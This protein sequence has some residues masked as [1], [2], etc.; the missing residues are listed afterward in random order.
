M[1]PKSQVLVLAT[2]HSM[3]KENPR[4]TYEDLFSLIDRFRA[5]AIGVEIRPEDLNQPVDYLR[6]SYPYEMIE[7]FQRYGKDKIVIGFDWLGHDLA[8]QLI[9]EGYW[10]RSKIKQL[11][12][13]F[14]EEP[15]LATARELL[16][17]CDEVR[18]E[19]IASHPTAGELNDGRYDLASRIYYQLLRN[20]LRDTRFAELSSFY[21]ERDT[22][23]AENVAS[24][25]KASPGKRL[26]FLLG[27]DHR[28]RAVRQLRK[29][30][31]EMIELVDVASV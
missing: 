10:Q 16:S 11:Q 14:A 9:P 27:G 19:I 6:R 17:V 8:G 29:D 4:Y 24:I 5:E 18:M 26:A 30:C 31:A 7:A 15:S 20:L 3:H 1:A 28:D 22:R 12:R 2:L 21:D 13:E 23:I 25:V